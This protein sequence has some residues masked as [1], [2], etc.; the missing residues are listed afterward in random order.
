MNVRIPLLD[1][2]GQYKPIRDEIRS[3]I[4]EVVETQ[5]FIL[6]LKVEALERE[7]AAYCGARHAIGVSSG[8]D[9]LLASLMAL[10]VGPGDEVITSAFS[11]FA[12]AGVIARLRAKPVFVD[13]EPKTFNTEAELI[14]RAVTEKTKAIIPVHLFGQLADMEPILEV[15]RNFGVP[16][17]ED[18]AQSIGAEFRG[19][20]AGSLGTMGTFS[21]FPS[22]NLGCFGDGGMI[23]TNDPA[24][25]ERLRAIRHHGA[26]RPYDHEVVGGNFRLDA[27]QAA[28]LSVKLKYLDKWS[29]ARRE[30]A[31]YYDR[32][33]EE[34]ELI[35]NGSIKK[36]A[37]VHAG[38]G[39]QNY[40]IYN[41]YT[42][43]TK[44]RDA[45][46]AHLERAGVG[47]AIYYPKPLH[48]QSCFA[49]LGN[50]KGAFP[51]AE[52]ACEEVLSIPI[53]PELTAEQKEYVVGA[54]ISFY[55]QSGIQ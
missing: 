19:K 32:R 1:L 3:A 22:K 53:Y 33:F 12:T 4:D 45:L 17:I 52:R 13:I 23:V 5:A 14:E 50:A 55:R 54:I 34:S 2:T 38:S 9:A 44:N 25:A 26:K 24:L 39:D 35:S 7:I 49:D 28:V 6:G 47:S 11:F 29:A 20:K 18:A 10:D 8:T 46:K 37:A 21:F 41:Q 30:N 16:I 36:P 27:L 15:S 40:H 43:R 31:K 48:L 51:E 42:L